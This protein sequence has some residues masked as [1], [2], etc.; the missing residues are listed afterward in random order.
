[1]CQLLRFFALLSQSFTLVFHVLSFSAVGSAFVRPFMGSSDFGPCASSTAFFSIRWPS[2]QES[3]P[4]LHAAFFLPS[5]P[6]FQ[7]NGGSSQYM[8]PFTWQARS[9]MHS[10]KPSNPKRSGQW[11]PSCCSFHFTSAI[12]RTCISLPEEKNLLHFMALYLLGFQLH[13]AKPYWRDKTSHKHFVFLC[14]ITAMACFAL[15]QRQMT[16]KAYDILF[17]AYNSP[18]LTLLSSAFFLAFMRSSPEKVWRSDRINSTAR[19]VFP[20]YLLHVNASLAPSFYRI[21]HDRVFSDQP[22]GLA[23][24]IALALTLPIMAVCLAIDHALRPL[25]EGLSHRLDGAMNRIMSHS[26]SLTTR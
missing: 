2:Q 5:F 7:A 10:Q 6:F 19:S 20:V 21:L 16:S 12:P 8:P 13:N 18:V 26:W 22:S 11:W 14:T 3:S 17:F 23:L 24:V 9:S 4:L 25:H 15:S 1:M